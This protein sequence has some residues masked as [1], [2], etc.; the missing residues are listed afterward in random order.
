MP[1]RK[2]WLLPHECA[3]QVQP[4]SQIPFQGTWKSSIPSET[5]LRI[6]AENIL[7][8]ENYVGQTHIGIR[9]LFR[10]HTTR[11]VAAPMYRGALKGP[12]SEP[13]AFGTKVF[14]MLGFEPLDRLPMGGRGPCLGW[15]LG[16]FFMV[17]EL[18][19]CGADGRCRLCRSRHRRRRGRGG[20]SPRIRR[21]HLTGSSHFRW[22]WQDVGIPVFLNL[23]KDRVLIVSEK[24]AN[25]EISA[26][27][28]QA[29]TLRHA[30]TRK[31]SRRHG[32][33]RRKQNGAELTLPA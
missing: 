9:Y 1:K 4:C 31:A 20:G 12:S 17:S 14:C 33:N 5:C 15:P 18:S 21:I 7:R 11:P 10:L 29:G 23:Q 6:S 16:G 28:V 3:P 30:C 32:A 19:G 22:H 8:S 24:Q 26:L 2:P 27:F 25:K 13:R